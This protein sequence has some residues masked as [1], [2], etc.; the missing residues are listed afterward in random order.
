VEI[1]LGV[2]NRRTNLVAEGVDCVVRAGGVREQL[3]SGSRSGRLGIIQA[4]S[5]AVHAAL[6]DGRL[7]AVLQDRQTPSTP[8][9]V[10]YASNRF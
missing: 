8:V 5:Y 7:V 9:H 3:L 2:A 4:P 6:L 1:E 10:L